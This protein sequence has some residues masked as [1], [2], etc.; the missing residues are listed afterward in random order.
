MKQFILSML[1]FTSVLLMSFTDPVGKISGSVIDQQLN[2]PIPYATVIIN[3]MQGNLVTGITSG[4][5]GDFTIDNV[6]A[7]NYVFKVQFIGYKTFSKEIHIDRGS[8]RVDFGTIALEPDVAMLDETVVVAERTT[9]EQRVDRK[10]INVGKDLMTTGASASEIMTNIPS[11]NVDQDGNISLRGNSNVRILVDG[12]P[13]NMDPAQLLKT[14]PSTSIKSIEL[15]TNPSAKYNPEGMS[16]IINIV[17]LKNARQG[18]NGNLNTGLTIG[19]HTRF[20]GSLDMNYRTGKFNFFGNLG[21]NFGTNQNGGTINLIDQ[22]TR[23][24]FSVLNERNSYLYK[25][26]VDFY[27]NEKNTFSFYT[28]QNPFSGGPSA[29]IRVEDFNNPSRDL[30]QLL[31]MN[32]ERKNSTYNFLFD[33]DFEKDGHD[34][35]VEL[36]YNTYDQDE[37]TFIS[38]ENTMLNFSP[39]T[40][41]LNETRE[42]FTGNIDYVNPLSEV[43]K[44]EM[45]AEVRL[46]DTDNNYRTT[47]ENY[48]NST[49]QYDRDIYSFY[50]TFGQ[51][52]EKWSYQLGARFE[53]YSVDAIY[54]GDKVYEDDYFTVYPSGFLSYKPGE[55]NNYQFSF[56]RRVDRPG[57]SQVN[58]IREVASP[59]LTVAGNPQLD[60]QFT[61]SFELNYTRNF[62]KKGNATAGVFFRRTTDEINQVFTADENEPGSLFLT[63]ANYDTNN[64]YG[65]E[66]ST[67]YKFTDW[68]STNTSFELYSQTL[69]GAVGEDFIAIDN[70][71]FTFRTNHNFKATDALTFSLFGYYRSKSQDLQLDIDDMYFVNAG[72]RYSFLKDDKATLSLN[73]NDIFNT[74][75]FNVTGG[76][77]FDQVGRFKG[78][79]QTVYLG[80]SY[81]FGGSKFKAVKRKNRDDNDAGG[82][83]LF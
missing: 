22:D 52:Y 56:S 58:P 59:R 83:G 26:G 49:Y 51:N 18:F 71:A 17:L 67:N 15:I 37:E 45:G 74:Q 73:F 31:D 20:N 23:Q 7:G 65:L 14:I 34:L 13:T 48:Q 46:L 25:I 8:P 28:N 78:E 33:H 12:K 64:S 41:W 38:F 63:F 16:G 10:V 82:G 80:F 76:R 54:Q 70:T 32:F 47:S 30:T 39:Y 66:L 55:K 60:P 62:T 44:L 61:N 68:W 69:K 36:D 24:T 6:R 29:W 77:P 5:N 50:T 9:I 3:D 21:A 2:E 43:S 27:L 53:N 1:L 79:T 40:D 81:R 35:Q 72:A 75:E 42:N 11:V 57:F 19:D 4:D